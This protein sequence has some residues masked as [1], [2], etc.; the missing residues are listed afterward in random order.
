MAKMAENDILFVLAASYDSVEGAEADYQAVKALYHEVAASH[1]FVA[2]VLERDEEGTVKVVRKHEQPTRH[3]SAKGLGWGLAVGAAFALL[4]A[5]GLA[6]ALA[7]AGGAGAA[8]GAVKGHVQGGMR[9]DDL[10]ELGEVLE[11]GRAGLIVVYATNMADQ[12]AAS[13]KAEN[14]YV[15]KQIDANADELAKQIAA[16]G[17]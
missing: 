7:T 4:P 1:D 2:A 17:E 3:G 5:I 16:A 14:R 13:I 9:D 8:I 15:S 6:G 12:I 11:K 10:K